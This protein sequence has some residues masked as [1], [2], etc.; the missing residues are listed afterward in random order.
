MIL[1]H[2]LHGV[3]ID[4]RCAQIAQLALWMRAQ[5][6]YREFEISRAER[7]AIRRSNI[8]VAEPPVADEQI[9]KEFVGKLGDGELERVFESLLVEA[10]NLVGDMGLLCASRSSLGET[11]GKARSAT[12]FQPPEDRIRV[13]LE[14]FMTAETTNGSTRRQ[15]FADDAAHGVALLSIAEKKFDVV[16]MNPPF[17]E[18]SARART[19]FHKA[20]PRTKNDVYAAFV[21][22]SIELLSLTRSSRSDH[23][24]HRILSIKLRKMA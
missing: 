24:A 4:P 2:N 8:V 19:E 15:L 23:L 11:R 12:S 20:Y 17:G 9:A 14:R 21:E 7:T 5:K 6:A 16:L 13:A 22:R 3:D 1:A 10:L 18:G